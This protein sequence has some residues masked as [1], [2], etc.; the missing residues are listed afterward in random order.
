MAKNVTTETCKNCGQTIGALEE[1]YIFR[2]RPVCKECYSRLSGKQ[3]GP[4]LYVAVGAVGTAI[5]AARGETP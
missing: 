1:A 5:L 2:D 4:L 3:K